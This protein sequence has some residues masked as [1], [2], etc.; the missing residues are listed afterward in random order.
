MKSRARKR[1]R[2]PTNPVAATA[3]KVDPTRT[4]TLRRGVCTEVSKRLAKVRLQIHDLLVREQALRF[5]WAT[6]PTEGKVAAVTNWVTTLLREALLSPG[7][8]GGSPGNWW[9]GKLLGA[10][11][12][13][14]SR[15]HDDVR[16]RNPQ[17][18]AL[19][20][21]GK[22]EFLRGL[23]R[24]R[25]LPRPVTNAY[26]PQQPRDHKGKWSA[27]GKVGGFGTDRKSVV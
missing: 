8:L 12:R 3:L 15:S 23:V 11:M 27:E 14:A 7:Q 19:G 18:A 26:N 2:V 4:L 10:Y 21:G 24:R 16:R 13:G 9:A 25:A 20:A 1:P 22:G 6:L 5:R 17:L